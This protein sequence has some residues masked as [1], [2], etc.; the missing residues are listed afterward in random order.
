MVSNMHLEEIQQRIYWLLGFPAGFKP[1]ENLGIFL[2]NFV[3]NIIYMWNLIATPLNKMRTAIVV[4]VSI[5]G[6]LG[7]SI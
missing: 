4:Y 6:A 3:L 5:F 2:G 7:C 1:N